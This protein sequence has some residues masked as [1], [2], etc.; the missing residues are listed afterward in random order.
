MQ[1]NPSGTIYRP[2]SLCTL[3]EKTPGLNKVRILP[4][5]TFIKPHKAP[6]IKILPWTH[7]RALAKQ[8]NTAPAQT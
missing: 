2:L 5:T 4:S 1:K 6:K 8:P 3:H 7:L